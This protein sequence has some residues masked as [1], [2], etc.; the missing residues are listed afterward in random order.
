MNDE[1]ETVNKKKINVENYGKYDG[2]TM[3]SRQ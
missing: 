1:E 2:K 3:W